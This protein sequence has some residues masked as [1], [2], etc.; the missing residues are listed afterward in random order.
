MMIRL[1]DS[2]A[3]PTRARHAITSLRSAIGAIALV[4]LPLHAAPLQDTAGLK[5][6]LARNAR[7]PTAPPLMLER[8]SPDASVREVKLSPDGNTI[9][10]FETDAQGSSL[11]LLDTATGNKRR[12]LASV[13]RARLSWSGD[14]RAL[15]LVTPSGVTVVATSDGASAK[16]AAFDTKLEQGYAGVILGLPQQIATEQRDP[17]TG[18]YRLQGVDADGKAS[19]L[20]EGKSRLDE[21]TPLVS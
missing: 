15:F 6:I 1:H 11:N 20:Y 17:A 12:L 18:H 3:E 8:L 9:A 10:F 14:S 5:A 7:L 4:C 19:V 13:A 21:S 16:I 2:R